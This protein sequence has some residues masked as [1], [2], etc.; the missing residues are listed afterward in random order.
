[1][2]FLSEDTVTS[3]ASPKEMLLYALSFVEKTYPLFAFRVISA[4]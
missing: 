1:M 2:V 4:W 3:V